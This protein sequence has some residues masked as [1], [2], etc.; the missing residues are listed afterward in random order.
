MDIINRTRIDD[1]IVRTVAQHSSV[2]AQSL[3]VFLDDRVN[4]VRADAARETGG[5]PAEKLEIRSGVMGEERNRQNDTAPS[6]H[7]AIHGS[8]PVKKL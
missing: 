4:A 1:A 6:R 2:S 3:V 5:I 7:G 8:L